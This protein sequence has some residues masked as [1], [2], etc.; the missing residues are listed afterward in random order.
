MILCYTCC[1]CLLLHACDGIAAGAVVAACV[2]VTAAFVDVAV[3]CDLCIS[4]R[5][6][7]KQVIR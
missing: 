6:V 3:W 7:K 1:L 4:V 5:L 2:V